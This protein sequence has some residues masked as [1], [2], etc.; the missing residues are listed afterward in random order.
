MYEIQV[1]SINT[2]LTLTTGSHTLVIRAWDTVSGFGDQTVNITVTGTCSGTVVTVS[3]PANGVEC[4]LSVRQLA[5]V[6]LT[7]N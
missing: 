7:I 3:T 6:T 1:N 2:N 5:I 4:T